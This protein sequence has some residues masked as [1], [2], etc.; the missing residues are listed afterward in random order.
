MPKNHYD[1]EI[2]NP[3]VLEPHSLAK[4]TILRR[5]VEEYVRILTQ[6]GQIPQLRLSIVDG[7]AG[8]GEYVIKDST[9]IHDGSP[10]IL[11]NAVN[12]AKARLAVGRKKPIDIDTSF[13]FVEKKQSNF[14]YLEDALRRRVDKETLTKTRVIHGAFDAYLDE[15]IGNI[16]STPGRKARPIFILDQYGYSDVP[17]DMIARIM[18]ELPNAEVF[19]TLAYGWIGAYAKG[20]EAQ[21]LRIKNSLNISPH[22]NDFADG[23]RDIDEITELP[24][25]DR[26]ATL[27]YIQ[28][29][30][31]EGFAK[32][33]GAR[34]YTPFFITS[35]GSNRSYW[36]LHLANS[37]RAND[38][39]KSLH[40]TVKNHFVHYGGS[41]LMMLGYDPTR[42]QDDTAQKA[43]GF[44]KPARDQ[45]IEALLVELPSRIQSEFQ[46]GVSVKD[47]Y[48][49]IANETPASKDILAESLQILCGDRVL[50]KHGAQGEDRAPATKLKDDDII[51]VP[52]QRAWSF[53]KNE[54]K[55]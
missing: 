13:V 41:G 23:K 19:L 29:L 38:V 33:S 44:D 3:S 26:V 45:T 9:E 39:V 22:L 54:T 46:D 32:Q 6:N 25:N 48:A 18:R 17:V 2:G 10:L 5:Y 40:W 27:R 43:F 21:A 4:H 1:W 36:F 55:K 47:L 53:S 49:K 28:Q 24:P 20:P 7:F 14:R 35:K 30:L 37:A 12:A 11:I 52:A 16:K 51:R 34:C 42:P 50:E 31:H 15:I 8:G